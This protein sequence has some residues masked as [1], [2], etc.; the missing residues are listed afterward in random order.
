M[1]RYKC[2][3]DFFSDLTEKSAYWLGF[4]YA[5]GCIESSRDR[6]TISLSI[7]D[8]EH[9]K[10]FQDDIEATHKISFNKA[11]YSEKYKYTEKCSIRI[12]SKKIKEDLGKLGCEPRKSLTCKFPKISNEM[13]PHFIRGYF[14]GDGSVSIVKCKNRKYPMLDISIIGTE[15]FLQDLKIILGFSKEKALKIDKRLKSS[16]SIR[17]LRFSGRFIGEKFYNYIYKDATVFLN[18]KREKFEEFLLNKEVQRL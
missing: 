2:N 5:D 6:L 7:K 10:K 13:I 1:Q 3:F 9:L 14:D 11:R 18:R 17:T 16:I 12:S 4:I 8:L 15:S